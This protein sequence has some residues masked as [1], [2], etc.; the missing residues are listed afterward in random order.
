M[1]LTT[2]KKITNN[3]VFELFTQAFHPSIKNITSDGNYDFD[4]P[5]VENYKIYTEIQKGIFDF[6]KT[7]SKFFENDKW[8]YNI[9]GFDAYRPFTM[10]VRNENFFLNNFLNIVYQYGIGS[11][12]IDK[13]IESLNDR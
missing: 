11:N 10:T 6:C 2:N 4:I 1:H 3:A 7:Y 13:K 8:L 9:S 12:D 5:E